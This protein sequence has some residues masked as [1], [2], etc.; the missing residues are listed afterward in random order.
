MSAGA[1]TP[2]DLL[3]KLERLV[4]AD[5]HIE[6]LKAKRDSG[7]HIVHQTAWRGAYLAREKAELDL[8]GNHADD[9]AKV[10]RKLLELLRQAPSAFLPRPAPELDQ[11]IDDELRAI[12]GEAPRVRLAREVGLPWI[13]SLTD[14]DASD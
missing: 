7:K 11:R 10:A 3:R 14:L 9:R 12:H 4:K 8:W 1:N 5:D 6:E 2:A 13:N